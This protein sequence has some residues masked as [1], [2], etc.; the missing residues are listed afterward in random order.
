M[1]FKT[2]LRHLL[3]PQLAAPVL[4]KLK[5]ALKSLALR[6]GNLQCGIVVGKLASWLAGSNLT[7]GLSETGLLFDSES[8]FPT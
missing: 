3:R 8:G 7:G 1:P 6:L 2:F 5:S 4:M